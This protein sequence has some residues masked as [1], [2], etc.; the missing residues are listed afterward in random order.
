[1]RLSR[2]RNQLNYALEKSNRA[3]IL[4][5][6]ALDLGIQTQDHRIRRSK[7]LGAIQNQFGF[8]DLSCRKEL[9]GL[10]KEFARMRP[11]L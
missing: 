6:P 11:P 10:I 5:Q 8:R 3:A 9:S 4:A 1:V 2:L 7:F